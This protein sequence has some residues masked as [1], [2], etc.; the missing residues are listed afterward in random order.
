MSCR[1]A[2]SQ[3][4]SVNIGQNQTN[5]FHLLVSFMLSCVNLLLPVATVHIY[6]KDTEITK[7]PQIC[8]VTVS[9]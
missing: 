8:T 2:G 4:L 5:C 7:F 1:G 9:F 3:M 6:W